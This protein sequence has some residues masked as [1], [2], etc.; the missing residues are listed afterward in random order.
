[1]C[2]VITQQINVYFLKDSF[3]F[4]LY[5]KHALGNPFFH[6]EGLPSP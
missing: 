1:M 3:A 5:Q 4:K 6:I 2:R